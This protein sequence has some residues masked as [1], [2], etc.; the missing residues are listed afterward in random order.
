MRRK[1]FSF[2]FIFV[3]L[4]TLVGCFDS[5]SNVQSI[6]IKKMGLLTYETTAT[7]FDKVNFEFT[8]KMSDG[9]EFDLPGNSSSL[10]FTAFDNTPGTHTCIV[11]YKTVNIAITYT[12]VYPDDDENIV[13]INDMSELIEAIQP[14]NLENGQILKLKPGYY[15]TYSGKG[16]KYLTHLASD[17]CLVIEKSVTLTAFDPDDRP[18]LYSSNTGQGDGGTQNGWAQSTIF[19]VANNVTLDNLIVYSAPYKNKVVESTPKAQNGLVIKNCIIDGSSVVNYSEVDGYSVESDLTNIASS[20]YLG[21]QSSSYLI[22]DNELV[23]GIAI[24][25]G[26]GSL[27]QDSTTLIIRNNVIKNGALILNGTRK[28][29]WDLYSLT[30][31][32]LIVGN[33]FNGYSTDH[34]KVNVDGV[35]KKITYNYIIRNCD[36]SIENLFT[37]TDLNSIIDN[38]TFLYGDY[39]TEKTTIYNGDIETDTYETTG[40]PA[41]IYSMVYVGE[42]VVE[43][44]V[45]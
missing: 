24:C 12:V 40:V 14:E 33:T 29:N 23:G 28:T 2:V 43:D 7:D 5:I 15:D 36:L 35:W 41:T 44:W 10:T 8:I 19:V 25:N 6:S 1:L 32:P 42:P 30:K 4:F 22:E 26:S 18:I 16:S 11:T 34:Y 20:I 39:T 13:I 45:E 38:N 3:T 21:G 37:E 31:V 17:H 9:T 27:A